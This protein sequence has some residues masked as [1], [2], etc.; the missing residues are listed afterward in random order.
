MKSKFNIFL[1]LGILGLFSIHG[2]AQSLTNQVENLQE[3]EFVRPG[4]FSE[5]PAYIKFKKD[6]KFLW[7][8]FKLG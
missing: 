3:V 8:N 6:K 4:Q 1:T 2:I 7:I 5:L